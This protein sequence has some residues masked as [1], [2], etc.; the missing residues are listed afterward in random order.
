MVQ[1][2]RW[3]RG[4]MSLPVGHKIGV[5][6]NGLMLPLLLLLGFYS[7]K[8]VV[9]VSVVHYAALTVWLVATLSWI[10]QQKLFFALPAF[11]FYH[12]FTNFAMILNYYFTKTTT[13]KGRQYD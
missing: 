8:I 9:V 6:A 12:L 13:W 3:M 7:V 1:R 4:A 2:K 5:F 11:W 10:G